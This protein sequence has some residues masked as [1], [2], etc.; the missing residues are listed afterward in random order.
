MIA[1]A[2]AGCFLQA[3]GQSL[4]LGDTPLFYETSEKELDRSLEEI[5]ALLGLPISAAGLPDFT[6]SGQFFADNAASFLNEFCITYDLDWLELVFAY[7]F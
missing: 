1:A 7:R 2:A 6:V 5:S 3:Q 4:E